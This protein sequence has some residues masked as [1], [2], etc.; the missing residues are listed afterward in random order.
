MAVIAI[1][2][3]RTITNL[4]PD[5][6]KWMVK[7][8]SISED[9]IPGLIS[10]FYTTDRYMIDS[11]LLER[12]W[13]TSF[14]R[15]KVNK[16]WDL[17]GI[18]DHAKVFEY[19]TVVYRKLIANGHTVLFVSHCK[20]GHKF[21][22]IAWLKKVLDESNFIFIDT[23]YKQFINADFIIDDCPGV[24]EQMAKTSLK[25]KSIYINTDLPCLPDPNCEH[26]KVKNWREINGY[27]EDW[28]I[29][30]N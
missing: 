5:W 12:G 17:P 25:C 18:Y 20:E 22:K 9:D 3:D 6:C 21:S 11:W 13:I 10:D 24:H 27:F 4:C 16:F 28:G 14:Q 19:F 7:E 1:D 29:I 30:T 23:K 26:Y 8:F 2:V 15:D